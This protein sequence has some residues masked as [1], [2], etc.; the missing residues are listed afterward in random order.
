MPTSSELT[1]F[2]VVTFI[3]ILTPGPNFIYI[4][5]RG[6]T[7]GR[8]AGLLAAFGLG[9]GVLV[10]T[11]L[12][13][14]GVAALLRASYLAF[15]I[16]KYGGSL[17]LVYL[18][19]RAWRSGHT[20]VQDQEWQVGHDSVIIWQSVVASLTNPKT[21]LFFVSVL[22]QF[23]DPR[24]GPVSHQLIVLGSIYMLITCVGYGSLAYCAGRM[25]R[26]LRRSNAMATR[27]RWVTGTSFI[28][29]GVW[30][31]LPDRR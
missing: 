17:Y 30:A 10:H 21:I 16:V 19:V 18:G 24:S 1:V 27:L 3:L 25:G 15:R 31:A 28:G 4:L 7:Q 5:T 23:V 9:L 20:L 11:I 26:W 14:I 13:A 2:C 22:P 8:R 6:A 29:L 12:A